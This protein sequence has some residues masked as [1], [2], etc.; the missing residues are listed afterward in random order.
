[1]VLRWV[2]KCHQLESFLTLGADKRHLD[3]LPNPGCN[4]GKWR[5]C[6]WDARV[7]QKWNV[8]LVVT[9]PGR[10]TQEMLSEPILFLT[11]FHLAKR[12]LALTFFIT[13]W[14]WSSKN[15]FYFWSLDVSLLHHPDE[16]SSSLS[17]WLILTKYDPSLDSKKPNHWKSVK[18]FQL[19]KKRWWCVS[20]THHWRMRK[21]NLR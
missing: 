2:A 19:P 15:V 6:F 7:A 4:R 8:L 1:M 17:A 5:S 3:P 10:T 13:F 11:A 18:W 14:W 20:T 16:P 21:T 9:I 12:S